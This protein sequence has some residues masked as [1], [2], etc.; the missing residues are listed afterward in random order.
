MSIY[1][2]VYV[3]ISESTASTEIVI[4]KTT[5]KIM[6]I[7]GTFNWLFILQIAYHM[8]YY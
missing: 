3:I 5:N 4:I 7:L 1:F 6:Y 8:N 2:N